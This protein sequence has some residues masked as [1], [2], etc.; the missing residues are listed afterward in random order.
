MT[1]HS[2]AAHVNTRSTYLR[3]AAHGRHRR[4]DRKATR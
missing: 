4:T 3:L 1:T 2:G